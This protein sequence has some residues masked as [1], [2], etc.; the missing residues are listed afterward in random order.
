MR[1]VLGKI[2]RGDT[3]AKLK[4]SDLPEEIARRIMKDVCASHIHGVLLLCFPPQGHPSHMRARSITFSVDE[5]TKKCTLE[6]KIPI[7]WAIICGLLKMR[8]VNKKF[9]RLMLDAFFSG[10]IILEYAQRTGDAARSMYFIPGLGKDELAE[11]EI[12]ALNTSDIGVRWTQEID[13]LP[14]VMDLTSPYTYGLVSMSFVNAKDLPHVSDVF[15]YSEPH[16]YIRGRR[17]VSEFQDLPKVAIYDFDSD[18]GWVSMPLLN[19][20]ALKSPEWHELDIEEYVMCL[21]P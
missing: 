2:G 8:T 17:F 3:K 20:I 4:F 21:G 9:G 7:N 5:A 15:V 14:P 6:S 12:S 11:R 18:F 19:I 10:P 13:P 1:A 16:L